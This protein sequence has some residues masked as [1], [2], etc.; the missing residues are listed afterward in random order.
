ML[1]IGFLLAVLAVGRRLSVPLGSRF[2]WGLGALA[3][4]WSVIMATNELVDRSPPSL[5]VAHV[6][7][8]RIGGGRYVHYDLR[9]A[10]SDARVGAR[11]VEVPRSAYLAARPGDPFCM[12]RRAGALGMPW[13]Q[14]APCP[15]GT[16]APATSAIAQLTRGRPA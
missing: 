7:S 1:A 15:P 4:S 11:E 3:W 12:A 13:L 14:R 16:R 8:K 2:L 10:S 6:L 9:I 5:V